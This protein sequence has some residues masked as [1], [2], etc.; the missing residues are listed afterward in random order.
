VAGKMAKSKKQ[1][2]LCLKW[3]DRGFRVDSMRIASIDMEEWEAMLDYVSKKQGAFPTFREAIRAA[4]PCMIPCEDLSELLQECDGLIDYSC[5]GE[6][7][8]NAL[9]TL[10]MVALQ[11]LDQ[12]EAALSVEYWEGVHFDT[13]VF[14]APGTDLL[15]DIIEIDND[16]EGPS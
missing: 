7:E 11:A 9:S 15:A 2:Q 6:P 8:M 10:S 12:R 13:Q 4:L 1:I 3:P 5:S 14:I 16:G